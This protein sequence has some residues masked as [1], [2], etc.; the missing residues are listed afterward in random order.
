MEYS[1]IYTHTVIINANTY[2]VKIQ[3]FLNELIMHI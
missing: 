3:I 1:S 2:F